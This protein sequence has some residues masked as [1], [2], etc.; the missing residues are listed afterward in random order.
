MPLLLSVAANACSAQSRTPRLVVGRLAHL[1]LHLGVVHH[2]CSASASASWPSVS[3][4][5]ILGLAESRLEVVER[6][7]A[8]LVLEAVEIHGGGRRAVFGGGEVLSKGSVSNSAR[9]GRRCPMLYCCNAHT[10][11]Y[12]ASSSG[13]GD[14]KARYCREC[15]DSVEYRHARHGAWKRGGAQV[16]GSHVIPPSFSHSNLEH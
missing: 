8:H 15:L 4:H 7:I 12:V 1:G 11:G 16:W 5:T 6:E 10:V 2:G 3:K 9:R 13:Y 14:S